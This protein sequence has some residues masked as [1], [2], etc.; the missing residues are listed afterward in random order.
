M[1][2]QQIQ[3]LLDEGES[4]T[5]EFKKSTGQLRAAL[6]TA[7]GFLNGDGGILVFGITD[8]HNLIGQT[9]SDKTKRAIG[10][11]LAKLSPTA[12]IEVTYLPRKPLKI[13]PG[14]TCLS[15]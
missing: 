10:N 3:Q 6:E 12:N 8:D 13:P 14:H 7:C 1:D 5:V 15:R 11:E 9:V 2:L 4:Q